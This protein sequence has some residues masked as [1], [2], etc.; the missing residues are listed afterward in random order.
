VLDDGNAGAEQRGVNRTGAVV[1]GIDVKGIDADESR[2]GFD[3]R[4]R[5]FD[6]EMRMALEVSIG[7]PMLV[8]AGVEKESFTAHSR[9]IE[10]Q[11]IDRAVA[12][13]GESNDD[14]IEIRQRLEF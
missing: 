3:Q 5:Q 6:G 11:T 13:I 14:A 8:P 4:L 9:E 2:A 10:G 1:G 7:A 12:A